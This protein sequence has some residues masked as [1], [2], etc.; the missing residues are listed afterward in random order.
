MMNILEFQDHCC[1]CGSCVFS[2]PHK[3][4]HMEK[5]R[6]GFLY[7]AVLKSRCI[8]CGQCIEACSFN[9]QQVSNAGADN[10]VQAY[11]AKNRDTA[12]RGKSRSGGV[13]PLLCRE[14][15][16]TGG[17]VYGCAMQDPFQAIHLRIS[18]EKE[19]NKLQGS[20][21]IQSDISACYNMVWKDLQE[22]KTVLFSGTPCQIAAIKEHCKKSE[23]HNLLLVDVVCHGAP[24]PDVWKAYLTEISKKKK[25]NI[26]DIDFRDKQ[27]FGWEAHKET[28]RFSDGTVFHGEA[29][30]ELF[31]SH[32]II[33]ECCFECPYKNLFRQG[34]ITLGDCW[35]IAENDPDFDDNKG[36]S[37]ILVNSEKGEKFFSAICDDLDRKKIDI[38]LYLQPPL[39]TNWEKPP[40]YQRF[41]KDFSEQPFRKILE[42]Y[43]PKP[44]HPNY[45]KKII[46]K[47]RKIVRKIIKKLEY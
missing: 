42:Q 10:P 28:V 17:V 18:S 34:D 22:G 38:N 33:R 14:V 41:W 31:Y 3:A 2:C 20:K 43:V 29:F 13:F 7:P 40:D 16:N 23:N 30:K 27:T 46:Q 4:I 25:A 5:N 37:L 1:G 11:A 45:R 35:G 8:E 6:Q 12:V 32:R 47:C 9:Q 19:I 26:T 24:S 15:F 36:V 21:Y 39:R 44:E